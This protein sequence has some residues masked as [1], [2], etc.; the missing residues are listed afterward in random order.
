MGI[1]S[2]KWEDDDDLIIP[3]KEID[4]L[5]SPIQFKGKDGR[6][7]LTPERLAAADT[8]WKKRTYREND[9]KKDDKKNIRNILPI[10]DLKTPERVIGPLK[11]Y[12][13]DEHGNAIN[14]REYYEVNGERVPAEVHEARRDAEIAQLCWMTFEEYRGYVAE[15]LAKTWV[16]EMYPKKILPRDEIIDTIIS[17]DI[18]SDMGYLWNKD[19]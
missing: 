11:D 7:Y 10:L 17:K 4:F 15:L 12:E 5:T 16:W 13:L 1:N 18:P 14:W 19:R 6:D 2:W 9:D 3:W 8:D